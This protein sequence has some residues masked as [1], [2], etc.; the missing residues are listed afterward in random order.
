METSSVYMCFPCYQ[1]F[2]TLEEVLTH[3]LTC[4]A[5]PANDTDTPTSTAPPT[6]S[7][8]TPQVPETE[9][10]GQSLL[11][12]QVQVDPGVGVALGSQ[13]VKGRQSDIPR[14]LYQC[15]DC[16]ILFDS[17]PLWQQHRK[18]GTCQEAEAGPGETD[19][20]TQQVL[21]QSEQ[22]EVQE[23]AQVESES[24]AMEEKDGGEEPAENVPEDRQA[25]Q[26]NGLAGR[27]DEETREASGGEEGVREEVS[28]SPP[29]R[30][31]GAG[32]KKAKPPLSL[33]C[34][35]CGRSF[36]LV[37]ELVSH[38]R[39]VH[40]LKEALHRCGVCGESFLNTTLFLYHR[41]QHRA[42]SSPA[43]NPAPNPDPPGQGLLLL[44]AAGEEQSL[45]L[46]SALPEDSTA[47]LEVTVEQEGMEV[48]EEPQMS[49]EEEQ[50]NVDAPVE[51]MD[52]EQQTEGEINE[53]QQTEGG[54]EVRE[55][56]MDE[57]EVTEDP[58]STGV[59]PSAASQSFLCSVCGSGF[60]A[61]GDLAE[62]RGSQHGLSA[63]LHR[64]PDCG[65]EFMNTTQFLYH[66]RSHRISTSHTHAPASLT[67]TLPWTCLSVVRRQTGASPC[68]QSRLTP[69]PTCPP[70]PPP[71]QLSRDWSRTAL[72]HAC[73]YCGRGFTRRC[74]LRAHVTS[75]TGEKLFSC[76]TCGKAFSSPSNLLRHT[77]T[78]GGARPFSCDLCD[79]SFFEA[80]TLKRHMLIHTHSGER[81]THQ[82]RRR[83]RGGGAMG[84]LLHHCPECPASF[85]LESQLQSHR[86]LHTSHPFP[87]DV[88]GEAFQRRK[89][90]DLHSLSH[91]DKEPVA[92]GN[93]GSLF[94]NQ[95]VLDAHLQRCLATELEQAGG[96]AKPQGRGRSGGQLE[97]DMCGHRCVTQDGLDLHRLSHTGQTP[98][99]C[100]LLPC[101][102]RFASS[103]ALAEHVLA[104]C[105]GT[106]VKGRAPRRFRCQHCGKEFAYASTFAVHMRIHTDERPF[107]CTHCGKRFR[108]LPHLQDHERI[109]SG[110][111]P[112]SC[113]VCG[114][115]F[116][117]AARLTEHARVHSGERPYA[118]TRCPSAFRS[119]PNLDKHMRLHANEPVPAGEGEGDAAVQTILLVQ[120][121]SPSSESPALGVAPEGAVVM[122]SLQ[123]AEHVA[124]A[125]SVIPGAASSSV[126][127]LH[128]SITM[129]TISMPTISMPSVTVPTISVVESDDVPHT[130]EFII[131]ETV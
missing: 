9:F 103:S 98:L 102:R 48:V 107:E 106:Q 54:E 13:Q 88:C 114:K 14:I 101:R 40:G 69:W 81:N 17:L 96:G 87:C 18:L 38:R 11:V 56:V 55:E 2:P 89:D 19:T 73:P 16:E 93:C 31:R 6:E 41:K 59:A 112:F 68:S 28:V 30:R 63:A 34:V 64:C 108:Q 57:G 119:R 123:G 49:V 39:T 10:I 33:L 75:H 27:E 32:P 61:E 25:A 35:D 128:P 42:S 100:P 117:V 47:R 45:L 79:K 129:P 70:P 92:C 72:P 50:T 124:G 83:G 24:G 131:E 78:H 118:C 74:Q 1:E 52:E 85:K 71:A 46:P 65:E 26:D 58:G 122:S 4:T 113:W 53:G 60:G 121:S 51:V 84:R 105:K 95:S 37:P 109:H 126:V 76:K 90:L 125:G 20:P 62:H 82:R 110:E 86:L 97:C 7:L 3:Q 44:A 120:S 115:S 116:S 127:F 21:V 130:I 91:Q 22:G 29:V 99:R 94:L 43:P 77:Q 67:Q 8:T 80:V 111:R 5:E 104:H 66:R 12:P 23:Q 36:S 15:A